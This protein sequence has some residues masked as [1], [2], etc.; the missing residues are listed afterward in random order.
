MWVTKATPPTPVCKEHGAKCHG[1]PLHMNDENLE[2]LFP[3]CGLN[4]APLCW[5]FRVGLCP[6]LIT[7][8]LKALGSVCAVT[9]GSWESGGG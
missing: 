3:F 9:L 7:S 8:P 5:E 1:C 2:S 6:R 4:A